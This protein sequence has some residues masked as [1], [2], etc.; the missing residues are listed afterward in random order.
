M[1][2]LVIAAVL[3]GVVLLRVLWNVFVHPLRSAA[4]ALK[5]ILGLGGILYLLA[6]VIGGDFGNGFVGVL[7]LMGAS[8]VSFV[9]ARR[10]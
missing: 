8:T 3:A 7:L 5:V 4:T 10:A 1:N 6:G 2:Y 9:Q